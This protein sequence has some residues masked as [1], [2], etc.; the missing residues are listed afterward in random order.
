MFIIPIGSETLFE[1]IHSRSSVRQS[2][3]PSVKNFCYKSTDRKFQTIMIKFWHSVFL[4]PRYNIF[5]VLA[6]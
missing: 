4:W 5:G 3:R 2:V 1:L 6:T